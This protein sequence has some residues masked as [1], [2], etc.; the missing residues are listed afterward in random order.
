VR[1]RHLVDRGAPIQHRQKMSG[2][3]GAALLDDVG[4]NLFRC[5][6]D[7]FIIADGE[8]PAPCGTVRNALMGS[9]AT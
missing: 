5:P 9:C 2:A 6:A 8:S 4:G 3:N 1:L 7:E